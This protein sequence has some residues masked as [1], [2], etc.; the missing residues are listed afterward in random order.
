VNSGFLIEELKTKV[1]EIDSQIR[2]LENN[3][4]T[5]LKRIDEIRNSED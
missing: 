2:R 3:K 4:E 1:K 5:I